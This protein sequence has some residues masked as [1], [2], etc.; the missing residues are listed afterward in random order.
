MKVLKQIFFTCAIA[1]GL[2]IAVCAQ[3]NDDQK[4]PPKGD[5]PV[6]NPGNKP[7]KGNPPKGDD[8][9]KPKKPGFAMEI[10]DKFF[11]VPTA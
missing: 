1:I 10:A 4:R 2:S 3:K 11:V 8:G 5:P 9:K 7:P 6:V